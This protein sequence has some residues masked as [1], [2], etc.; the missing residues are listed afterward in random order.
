MSNTIVFHDHIISVNQ[1]INTKETVNKQSSWGCEN[2][3]F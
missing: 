2:N 1:I 3:Y